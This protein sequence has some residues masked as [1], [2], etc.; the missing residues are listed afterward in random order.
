[1]FHGPVEPVRKYARFL[2]YLGLRVVAL[3]ET[4]RAE[5]Y[6]TEGS[7]SSHSKSSNVDPLTNIEDEKDMDNINMRGVLLYIMLEIEPDVY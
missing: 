6:S 4:C 5:D 1:M 3:A 2:G 7:V